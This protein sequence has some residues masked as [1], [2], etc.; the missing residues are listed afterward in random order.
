[1]IADLLLVFVSFAAAGLV[2]FEFCHP[3]IR[4]WFS[5]GNSK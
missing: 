2:Y 3:T 4:K 1:M 5:G